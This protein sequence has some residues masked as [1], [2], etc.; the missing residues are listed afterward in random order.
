MEQSIKPKIWKTLQPDIEGQAKYIYSPDV[1]DKE[2][3]LGKG[4]FGSV[5]KGYFYNPIT[6]I[7]GKPV[8]IKT[9][10]FKQENNCSN[11]GL[12]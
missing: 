1:T 6:Q 5:F 3:F 8:A 11:E 9:I 2:S 12:Q 4:E 7:S 10:K